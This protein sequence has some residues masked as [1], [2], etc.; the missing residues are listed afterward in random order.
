MFKI[1][2]VAAHSLLC[3]DIRA[4]AA[5]GRIVLLNSS[6]EVICLDPVT[7]K[8]E[9]LFTTED[10][11]SYADGG[12][13]LTRPIDLYTMDGYTAA[14]NRYGCHGYIFSESGDWRL[15]LDRE[16]YQAE[17]TP[18]PFTFF[19]N[20]HGVPHMIFA[21]A[22]NH[23][24]IANL[25]T[26]QVLTAA[27]ARLTEHAEEDHLAYYAS[28]EECSKLLWP[29]EYDYFYG[30]MTVSPDRKHFLSCGWLWGSVDAV[31]LYETEDF[32]TNPRIREQLIFTGEH[33]SRNACF[34]GNHFI[35]VPCNPSLDDMDCS[36]S[37]TPWEIRIF[38]F[39]GSKVRSFPVPFDCSGIQLCFVRGCLCLWSE[40][41]GFTAMNPDG[42]IL[43]RDESFCPVCMNEENGCFIT[44]DGG[45]VT[46][47]L[48][49]T[50][51]N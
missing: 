33:L 32:I 41:A 47:W 34:A 7:G 46:L 5:C 11:V 21:S 18:Y 22:W 15:H 12:F 6:G 28:H 39:T 51:E 42:G 48:L 43:L 25:E 30:K 9:I 20:E 8:T 1:T 24:Q 38:D 50:D 37:G 14:V 36:D 40:K 17:I 26:R 13:D 3:S 23:L 10:A 45:M 29:S 35:A 49:E 19:K 44:L 27:K 16:D 2:P 4:I 31:V